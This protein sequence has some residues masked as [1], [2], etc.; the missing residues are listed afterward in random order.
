[1][2][3]FADFQ[4]MW[5][6]RFPENALSSEWEDDVRV[7]LQRHKQ[8]VV[9]LSKELEQEMLYVE[10]LERLLSDVAEFRLA[11]GD[12]SVPIQAD[13]SDQS[14]DDKTDDIASATNE[15]HT[16]STNGV[17]VT[18]MKYSFC[19]GPQLCRCIK[20]SVYLSIRC[21][22]LH[23]S[24]PAHANGPHTRLTFTRRFSLRIAVGPSGYALFKT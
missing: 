2:S 17:C 12:P 1:M 19:V 15:E 5:M 18:C 8:K 10:Y 7:S 4:R 14:I 20:Q 16:A 13:A 3:V 21:S 22:M 23:I 11:G 24:H 6:K 9:D